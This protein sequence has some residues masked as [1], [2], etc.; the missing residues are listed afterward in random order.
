M[1]SAMAS[2]STSAQGRPGCARYTPR[3]PV[4]GK[5]SLLFRELTY[6]GAPP[7]SPFIGQKPPPVGFPPGARPAALPWGHDELEDTCRRYREWRADCCVGAAA[8]LVDRAVFAP[9]P[10]RR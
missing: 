7:S 9:F 10:P 6:P 5:V 4:R 1:R 3:L 2:P 8:L